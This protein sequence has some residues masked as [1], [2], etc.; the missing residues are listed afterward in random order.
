L[1]RAIASFIL[2]TVTSGCGYGRASCDMRLTMRPIVPCVKCAH[3][4]DVRCT[5][6]KWRSLCDMP[7]AIK[8][9]TTTNCV[10][11]T[12][13][14]D[15]KDDCGDG[16]D[17]EP[18][19]LLSCSPSGDPKSYAFDV[20]YFSTVKLEYSAFPTQCEAGEFRCLS[21]ECIDG[22]LVLDGKQDC[23]DNTDEEYCLRHAMACSTESPCSYHPDIAAFGCGCPTDEEPNPKGICEPTHA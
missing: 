22:S 2:Q 3:S 10:L 16:S 12:W 17:E 19:R 15:G 9:A 23:Y 7:D 5:G 14:M 11:L 13:I 8:C 20:M 1:C 6:Q 21:G 4:N 18:C